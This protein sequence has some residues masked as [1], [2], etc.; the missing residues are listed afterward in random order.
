VVEHRKARIADRA[1]PRVQVPADLVGAVIFF[2]SHDSAFRH[3]PDLGGR[4]W[5]GHALTGRGDIVNSVYDELVRGVVDLHC[6]I[7]MEFSQELFRKALPEWELL[8]RAEA[9]GMCGVVLKS[10]LRPTT[11]TEVTL[12]L[13]LARE[14][15]QSPR[16]LARHDQVTS[17]AIAA[18]VRE[19]QA[20][21]LVSRNARI[22][23]MGAG[24]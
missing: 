24:S 5:N 21:K 20:R 13:R 1:L 2:L 6:H 23:P 11:F 22:P 15:P 19:L 3:R 16:D 7:D 9:A 17:Q 14:G 10:H 18:I 8:P 12:L 4:R